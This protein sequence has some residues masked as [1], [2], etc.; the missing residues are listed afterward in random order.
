MVEAVACDVAIIGGGPAGLGA[1]IALRLR[2]VGR[3]I[4]FERED[5]AGGVPRHCGHPAFGM[6]EFGFPLNGP[7]YARRLRKLAVAHGVDI[8]PR[9]S[10]V[11]LQPNGCLSVATPDGMLGAE[12]RRVVLATGA[13]ETPRSARLVSGAR[14]LGVITTGALQACLYLERMQPACRRPVI[15][16]TELVGL[17]ALWTCIS[18]GIRPAAVIESAD[19]PVARWPFGLF[20]T[21]LGVPA[22]FGAHIAAI[23]GASRVERV[24]VQSGSGRCVPI[25]CDG[26]VFT[27][28]FVPEAALGQAASL[29]LD[30]CSGG[31]AID[32]FGR[33]SDPALFAAGN[34][35][36]PIETAGWCFR[37]GRRIGQAVADDLDG[38]L[39][40]PVCGIRVICGPGIKFCVP[41]MIFPPGGTR[42][43]THLDHLQLRVAQTVTG[44]MTVRQNGARIWSKRISTRPERRILI[45]LAAL[46]GLAA[47]GDI[48]LGIESGALAGER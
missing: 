41:H 40:P 26:V 47:S 32:Q 34:V 37:E 4:V 44:R 16:G 14:P 20:P 5:Q 30:P 7:H 2:Q 39:P 23:E 24:Q 45:P 15:V 18:H 42:S 36:R 35:L 48:M 11:A 33:C 13:R 31:P 29:A 25:A 46:A 28:R 10:V 6:R 17:S 38:R 3:V 21:L 1:A 9:H 43:A 22:Y 12:A 8:R 19:R 27:G